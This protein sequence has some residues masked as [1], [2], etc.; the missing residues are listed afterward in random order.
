MSDKLTTV[1]G[2]P[3]RTV[4]STRVTIPVYE[5]FQQVAERQELNLASLLEQI[6]IEHLN[7]QEAVQNGKR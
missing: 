2:R 5:R 6:V 3:I 4:L 1:T 7:K